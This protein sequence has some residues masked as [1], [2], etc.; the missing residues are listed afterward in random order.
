MNKIQSIS[1]QNSICSCGTFNQHCMDCMMEICGNRKCQLFEYFVMIFGHNHAV[2]EACHKYLYCNYE[3]SKMKCNR[4]RVHLVVI[5]PQLAIADSTNS[6]Y[7]FDWIIDM[8]YPANGCRLGE[9]TDTFTNVLNLGCSAE[10]TEDS[11]A[12]MAKS[13]SVMNSWIVSRY[14]PGQRILF[15]CDT[16]NNRSIVG[17][18]YFAFRAFRTPPQ[19]MYNYV[20][21][22][23]P[24]MEINS[25]FMDLLSITDDE[26]KQTTKNCR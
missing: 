20:K 3:Q 9:C 24:C 11:R 19:N 16:A 25:Q 14:R 21:T 1:S 23:R 15:R 6:Q 5:S 12:C 2:C 4:C 13:L 18:I 26:H 17:C 10:N 7:P 22:L 8:N